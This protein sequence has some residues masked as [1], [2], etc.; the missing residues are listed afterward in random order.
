MEQK[1]VHFFGFKKTNKNEPTFEDVRNESVEKDEIANS[2][3]FSFLPDL[4]ALGNQNEG[5]FPQLIAKFTDSSSSFNFFL[6]KLEWLLVVAEIISYFNL[7][8]GLAKDV[9]FM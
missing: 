2:H 6:S 4:T 3:L 1:T 7:V 8:W 5:I 9:N